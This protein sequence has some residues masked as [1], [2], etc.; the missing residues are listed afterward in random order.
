[1][2]NL[3]MNRPK[4]AIP[5]ETRAPRA[6]ARFIQNRGLQAIMYIPG[7]RN[8]IQA[9]IPAPN[10]RR[11]QPNNTINLPTRIQKVIHS[12]QGRIQ[13]VIRHLQGQEVV[14]RRHPGREA[15][16]PIRRHQVREAAGPILHRHVQVQA[17]AVVDHVH[18][19]A[20]V[21]EEGDNKLFILKTIGS[22]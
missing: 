9:G 11:R 1:M 3:Q 16:D 8:T 18:H 19:L 7:R 15:A 21:L 10:H 17:Q 22:N 13:K 12:P 20:V 6:I 2:Q 5:A 14:I 4:I